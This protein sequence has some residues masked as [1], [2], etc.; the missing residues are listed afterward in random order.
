M[1]RLYTIVVVGIVVAH[2]RRCTIVDVPLSMHRCSRICLSAYMIAIVG[3]SLSLNIH[4]CR[5]RCRHRRRCRYY[6]TKSDGDE[7]VGA[8]L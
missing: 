1:I 2:R 3:T 5:Y 4:R 7:G 8:E 6:A